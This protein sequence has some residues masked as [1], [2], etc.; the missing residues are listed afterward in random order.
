MFVY[1]LSHFG[2]LSLLGKMDRNLIMDLIRK[3]FVILPY[4]LMKTTVCLTL[5]TPASYGPLNKKRKKGKGVVLWVALS[6]LKLYNYGFLV[7]G[8]NSEIGSTP[9]ELHFVSLAVRLSVTP[10][11]YNFHDRG[12]NIIYELEPIERLH[13]LVTLDALLCHLETYFPFFETL[14]LLKVPL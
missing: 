8:P 10:W 6:F 13:T 1:L 4:I 7:F 5:P 2:S 14:N 3:T 12:F 11:M 9:W